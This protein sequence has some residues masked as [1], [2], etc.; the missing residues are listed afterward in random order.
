M[1]LVAGCRTNRVVVGDVLGGS[2]CTA[3]GASKMTVLQSGSV[4]SATEWCK[5]ASASNCG[6][7]MI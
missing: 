1:E 6:T 3:Q 4:C 2:N 7:M 5:S